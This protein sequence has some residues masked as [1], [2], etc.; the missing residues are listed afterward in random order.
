MSHAWYSFKMIPISTN[1]IHN[2]SSVTMENRP[3]VSVEIPTGGN[4]DLGLY[5]TPKSRTC[6]VDTLTK[7]GFSLTSSLNFASSSVNG[8]SEVKKDIASDDGKL[9]TMSGV[10]LPC[11]QNILVRLY[12]KIFDLFWLLVFLIML[13]LGCN[14]FSSTTFYNSTGEFV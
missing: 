10:L 1:H 9:G 11:L 7:N 13:R 5:S 4:F 14:P 6:I 8:E 12:F 3:R 2:I